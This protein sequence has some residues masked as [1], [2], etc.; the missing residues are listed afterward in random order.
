[1]KLF[2]KEQSVLSQRTAYCLNREIVNR[3]PI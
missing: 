1:M 2:D 3:P